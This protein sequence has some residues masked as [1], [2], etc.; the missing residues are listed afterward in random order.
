MRGE[1]VYKQCPSCRSLFVANEFSTLKVGELYSESYYEA[2]SSNS[3]GR[4]GYPSYKEA[5]ESLKDSFS[6]KLSL[7]REQVPTGRLLDAGAAYG[8]F[9]KVAHAYYDCVGLEVSEY[10]VAMAQEEFGMD[11]RLGN[12]EQAPFPDAEFDVIVMWDIIEHLRNPVLALKEVHRMLKPGGFCFISTDDV[13]NWFIKILGTKWWG[14][15]PPLHLCH[16]SK[17]GMFAA[18]EH[19][20]DF[21][22]V[23]MKKDRRRYSIP[24]VIR[25]FGVSY[26]SRFLTTLGTWI[27]RTPLGGLILDVARPEQFVA[28]AHKRI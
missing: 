25:H 6:R 22:F 1:F 19:A 8:T 12:V 18:L 26:Q 27:G 4:K 13:S 7:V 20:G 9:L 16:F 17:K 10:A 11:V 5:Q 2:D 24:E 15:A 23:E 14:V 3:K 28:I 21:D